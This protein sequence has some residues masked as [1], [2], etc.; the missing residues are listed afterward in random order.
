MLSLDKSKNIILA[1]LLTIIYVSYLACMFTF[2]HTHTYNNVVY[3]HSHPYKLFQKD[4][5]RNTKADTHEHTLAS[6]FALNQLCDYTSCE[7]HIGPHIEEVSFTLN[8]SYSTHYTENVQ[9][10][11]VR[12]FSLRAPPVLFC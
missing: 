12:H 10:K 5:E 11:D 6:L 8:Q 3:I 9:S 2:V 1:K 4:K 7:A